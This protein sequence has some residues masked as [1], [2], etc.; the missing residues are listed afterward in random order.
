MKKIGIMTFHKALSYGAGFQAYA[1]QKYLENCGHQVELIDYVPL[2]FQHKN[3]LKIPN[4]N[5]ILKK[6]IKC[7]PYMVCM[8]TSYR[9]MMRFGK[10]YLKL[11]AKSFYDEK[12][13]ES[14]IWDYDVFMTG[15]DQVW[16]LKF[17][18][19]DHIKPYLL[20]FVPEGKKKIAYAASVGMDG[21]NKIDPNVKVDYLKFLS[22]YDRISVRECFARDLLEENHV[23]AT[24]V[25][26]PT[27]L[28][29][30]EDWATLTRKP[31]GMSD[32]PFVYVY[33]LYRN[34]ELYK[35]AHRIAEEKNCDIVNMADGYDICRGA[36]NDVVVS[37]EEV[38]WY[39]KN[40]ECVLTDSFHG[41]AI[42]LNF[43]TPVYIFK[44]R[45][46]NTRIESIIRLFSLENRVVENVEQV[47]FQNMAMDYLK[48][49]ECMETERL[50]AKHY[51]KEALE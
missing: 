41:T 40:A 23:A 47:D 9:L 2:R 7:V 25:L 3:I 28:L 30:K 50:K 1:L 12:Q 36:H 48:I 6:A 29:N 39:L 5:N 4:A 11:S 16:N 20:S 38:L 17:D 8:E 49:N 51:L 26:D 35:L 19:F 21:F 22:Q 37:H 24:W 45:R 27:F 14:S 10:K 18:D 43:N 46:Y 42:S 32:K 44:A 31:R 33:G 13:M 15:S 34:R